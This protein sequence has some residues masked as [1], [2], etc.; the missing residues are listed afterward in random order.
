MGTLLSTAVC[1]G[2]DARCTGGDAGG[3]DIDWGDDSGGAVVEITTEASDSGGSSDDGPLDLSESAQRSR[4]VNDLM[5]VCTSQTCCWCCLTSRAACDEQLETF[6]SVRV[7]E[8]RAHDQIRLHA[9]RR[10]LCY[11]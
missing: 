2:A 8:V 5:E 3:V 11:V 7:S 9:C 4:L 10:L 6:L 1:D